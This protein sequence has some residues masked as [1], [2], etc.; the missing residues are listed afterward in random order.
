MGMGAE[1][2]EVKVLA[3]LPGTLPLFCYIKTVSKH[4]RVK[5]VH[6]VGTET[7]RTAQG[8]DCERDIVLL[9]SILS[10][11]NNTHPLLPSPQQMEEGN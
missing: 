6:V 4:Q 7:D 10:F 2:L 1:V 11:R 9:L 3:D 5:E 8:R